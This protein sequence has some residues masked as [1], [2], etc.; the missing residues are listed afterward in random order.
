MELSKPLG[1]ATYMTT[2][3]LKNIRIRRV[4]AQAR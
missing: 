1:L 4:D 2:A 3:A